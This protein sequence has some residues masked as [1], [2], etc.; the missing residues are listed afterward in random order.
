M[1]AAEF[2]AQVD[3]QRQRKA[4]AEARD[5]L[6]RINGMASGPGPLANTAKAAARSGKTIAASTSNAERLKAQVERQEKERQ[7]RAKMRAHPEYFAGVEWAR[8]A[9]QRSAAAV[10]AVADIDAAKFE[11]ALDLS[12]AIVRASGNPAPRFTDFY[13]LAE[14]LNPDDPA[15]VEYQ[16][17]AEFVRGVRDFVNQS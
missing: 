15:A 7:E 17:V 3:R 4:R 6:A 5:L 13:R 11:T 10:L 16:H 1:N 12:F 2:W 14:E 8:L 9:T